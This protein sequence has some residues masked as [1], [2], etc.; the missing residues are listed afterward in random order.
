MKSNKYA[1]SAAFYTICFVWLTA[2]SSDNT[3]D[4]F[5]KI[6]LTVESE[7]VEF[8]SPGLNS[9]V[10]IISGNGGYRIDVYPENPSINA[11]VDGNT[12]YIQA[13]DYGPSDIVITDQEGVH[14][15][16]QV[17]VYGQVILS[18]YRFTG[19]TSDDSYFNFGVKSSDFRIEFGKPDFTLTTDSDIGIV[20]N[21]N[22]VELVPY[23]GGDL[24]VRVTDALGFYAEVELEV[25]D[26][27]GDF[28][29]STDEIFTFTG[30]SISSSSVKTDDH[31]I[32]NGEYVFHSDFNNINTGALSNYLELRFPVSEGLEVGG[33]DDAKLTYALSS[34]GGAMVPYTINVLA[35]VIKNEGG[36]IW[37]VYYNE[38]L[39]SNGRLHTDAI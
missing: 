14:G 29:A 26:R 11:S 20:R 13:L 1:L 25:T 24:T 7:M 30:M 10:D 5:T 22:K 2:C 19:L 27:F 23:E 18:E 34:F 12:I 31:R 9:T 3:V 37:I 35:K 38:S 4:E 36:K 17:M 33:K 21:G 8:T 32:E 28:K 39:S 16:I 15:H 6:D